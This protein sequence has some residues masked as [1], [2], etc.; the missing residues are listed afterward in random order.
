M[1]LKTDLTEEVNMMESRVIKPAIE[2]KEHIQPIRKTIK[3]RENKRLD[4]ERWTDKVNSQ[5][6]KMSRSDKENA[7]L[8]KSKQ[9]LEQAAD[10]SLFP[11]L[12]AALQTD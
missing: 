6:R 7:S 1:E 12:C 4:W 10:V 5:S 8:A 3:K 2:A 11:D 9:E